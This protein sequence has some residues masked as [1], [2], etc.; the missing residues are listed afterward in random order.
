MKG[1][2]THAEYWSVNSLFLLEILRH[3]D[4]LGRLPEFSALQRIIGPIPVWDSGPNKPRMQFYAENHTEEYTE[5]KDSGIETIK[6]FLNCLS[7]LLGRLDGKRFE[8]TLSE[9]GLRISRV[10]ISQLHCADAEVID[11]AVCLLKAV[12]F[13]SNYSLAGSSSTDTREMDAV[14]PLLLHLLDERDGTARA[15]VVLIAENC[16]ISTDS[17]CL[18]EV[19]N[20][21]ASGDVVQRRNA[22]DVMSELFRI[23]PHLVHIFGR[24]DIANHLLERLGDEESIVRTQASYLIPMMACSWILLDEHASKIV[25]G[26]VNSNDTLT[27][28]LLQDAFPVL[29]YIYLDED[30]EFLRNETPTKEISIV[31]CGTSGKES[32]YNGEELDK[33]LEIPTKE[34]CST[35][36]KENDHNGEELDEDLE[37]PTKKVS[38]EK[39]RARSGC[40]GRHARARWSSLLH[41]SAKLVPFNKLKTH[42]MMMLS[43][44]GL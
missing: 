3:V 31:E 7:L 43:L 37:T 41:P 1:R 22:V 6:F 44:F 21:L 11:G 27:S 32:D 15:V 34:E 18:Q 23:S 19:L 38:M 10:L 36:G 29:K 14:L 30:L 9:D 39:L 25:V 33:D 26:N 2:V 42:L 5:N 20:R 13:R 28:I 35:S 16:S 4:A 12:I 17:R 40:W 24:Q 8:N